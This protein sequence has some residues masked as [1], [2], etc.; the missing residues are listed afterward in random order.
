[1]R[2]KH[3][4]EFAEKQIEKLKL[5]VIELIEECRKIEAG[6]W[7]KTDIYNHSDQWLRHRHKSNLQQIAMC[8]RTIVEYQKE[9]CIYN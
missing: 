7:Y 8:E 9:Y 1:M 4:K 3:T 5:R 6:E 2:Y